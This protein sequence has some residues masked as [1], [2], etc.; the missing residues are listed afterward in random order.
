[1]NK[2][3]VFLLIFLFSIIS[4]SG[5]SQEKYYVFLKDKKG[6]DFNPYEYF[7]AKAIT[8]R[9]KNNLSLNDIT[10]YP[11]NSNYVEEISE[12]VYKT[13][14]KSRWFNMIVVKAFPGEIEYVR[15]LTYVKDVV[16][17]PEQQLMIAA[18]DVNSSVSDDDLLLHQTESM[19]GHIFKDSNI[20]GKGVRIAIFDVGFKDVDT[21]PAFEQ[22][23]KDGR[24]LKTW[25]FVKND[26]FVYNYGTHGRSVFSCIAG[27][28]EGKNIGL[29]SAAEFI[30]ARTEYGSKE[31]FSEEENWLAAA[32][33]ADK[34]GVD[35]INSSLGYTK[36]RYF[37][38][39]MDGKTS[40]VA[41]AATMAARKGILVVNAMG[42]EGT[43]SWK[44]L[45]TPADA[46]SILSIGGIN[47]KTEIHAIFSSY[48]PTADN[49]RKPNVSAYGYVMAASAE[50]LHETQ[51]TSFSSPLVAGFAACVLQLNPNYTN[52]DLL[53]E[54]E[55]SGSLYPYFDYAHGYGIP[56]AKYFIEG[57][58]DYSPSFQFVLENDSLII[59]VDTSLTN[60]I[61]KDYLYYHIENSDGFVRKY[62]VLDVYRKDV[63][64]FGIDDFKK[65]ERIE[66]FYKGFVLSYK[67]K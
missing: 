52:M 66:A 12:S 58:T 5:F 30:L 8:R 20:N 32:E 57:K 17:V 60:N 1:M 24:M 63:I 41:K 61:A 46:D 49:R 23:R 34:N 36:E 33:W 29:A 51:G 62:A 13:G 11:L 21:H 22:I 18:Y 56:Q 31:P 64:K 14:I 50:K 9:L 15:Q 48:G 53:R 2:N 47:P 39:D 10:D 27:V 6:V 55:K 54:I 28:Y 25:D 16:K 7:D 26:E 43:N 3:T 4:L 44:T 65:D 59:R 40:L 45:G 67:F 35:I 19:G 37:P 42:N 38:Y